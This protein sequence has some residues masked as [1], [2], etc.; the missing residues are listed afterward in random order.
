MGLQD[1]F[2]DSITNC[3][4]PTL[5]WPTITLPGLPNFALGCFEATFAGMNFILGFLPPNPS[6]LPSI[7]DISLFLNPF[8]ASLNMPSDYPA[9]NMSLSGITISIPAVGSGISPYAL[10]G[11]F[12]PAFGFP[13]G[14]EFNFIFC[15][16][17]APFIMIKNMITQILNIEFPSIPSFG[18]LQAII[19]G[20]LIDIGF[21]SLLLPS[22]TAV[23][24]FAGCLATAI[25]GLV[26]ALL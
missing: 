10:F 12:D 21:G 7:P 11:P 14:G 23:F 2:V 4:G 6:N 22:L 8:M 15:S 24:N 25:I 5:T 18:A 9:F 3:M 13:V 20:L 19:T 16:V 26:T 1:T 17:A